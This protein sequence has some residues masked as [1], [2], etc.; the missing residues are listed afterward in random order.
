MV[1]TPASGTTRPGAPQQPRRL[2][3]S[4]M[5]GVR[6]D[7]KH[8][9]PPL[10]TRINALPEPLRRFVHAKREPIQAE[11]IVSEETLTVM[12]AKEVGALLVS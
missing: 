5:L 10:T 2:L 3:V 9:V 4:S 7:C 8:T 12:M 11:A 1:G 6:A